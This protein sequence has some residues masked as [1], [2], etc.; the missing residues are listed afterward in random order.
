MANE[1]SCKKYV[2][3]T[4]VPGLTSLA[5]VK[6]ANYGTLELLLMT[7]SGTNTVIKRICDKANLTTRFLKRN[8]KI[9]AS[10]IN[11]RAYFTFVGPF[12]NTPAGISMVSS[13]LGKR[14][15]ARDGIFEGFQIFQEQSLKHLQ[16]NTSNIPSI[17]N[18][19][20]LRYLQDRRRGTRLS[21][22]YKVDKRLVVIVKDMELVSTKKKNT[23]AYQVPSCMTD[24][25]RIP[26]IVPFFQ[27]AL[28]YL[29]A[30]LPDNVGVELLDALDALMTH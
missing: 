11:E 29:I 30:Q 1:V 17:F 23:S 20:K 18:F 8:L 9:G 12:W 6:S 21:M 19:L 10:S 15:E 25:R 3:R 13:H 26:R 16:C 2:E 14:T 28:W 5:S 7:R 4:V 24:K 22:L 27:R